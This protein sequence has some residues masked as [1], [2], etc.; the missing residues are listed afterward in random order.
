MQLYQELLGREGNVASSRG[1]NTEIVGIL[2]EMEKARARLS[3]SETRGRLYSSLG[4]LLWYL[5]GDNKLDFIERYI[6]AYVDESADGA[7]VHG[8]YGRR[9]SNQR[10]VGQL[11]NVIQ[12]LHE[13]PSSRRAVIQIFNAEDL[14]APH[15]EIPCTTTLQFL[16]RDERLHLLVTMRSNDAY[17]GLPHDVFCFTMLQEMIARSLDREVGTY[18]HFAGSMHLYDDHRPRAEE[19]ISE[20]FQARKEMPPMPAGAPWPSVE[21]VLKAELRARNG[22]TFDA[23]EY[24]LDPYWTDIIRLLQVHFA[25]DHKL[26]RGIRD[27]M[28]FDGYRPFIDAKLPPN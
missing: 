9:L 21:V 17:L 3:S 23:C 2:I 20:G 11:T 19:L 28:A 7:T 16:I 22:E 1:N 6:P 26:I 13:R 10:G 5:T 12:L 14:A 15:K 27:A 8:G 24:G 4:E 18:H 25:S